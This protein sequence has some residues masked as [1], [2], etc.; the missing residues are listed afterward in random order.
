M[1]NTMYMNNY[2]YSFKREIINKIEDKKKS[3]EYSSKVYL[4]DLEDEDN[5]KNDHVLFHLLEEDI[6]VK[7]D[8]EE[9]KFP[10][11]LFF[12]IFSSLVLFLDT[13]RHYCKIL[14]LENIL[15]RANIAK[16]AFEKKRKL[17]KE[18]D[19]IKEIINDEEL[20]FF[21]INESRLI[22]CLFANPYLKNENFTIRKK[23]FY[24][25]GI[26]KE[27]KLPVC[28]IEKINN[29]NIEI[30]GSI[31]TLK[32]SRYVILKKLREIYNFEINNFDFKYKLLINKINNK[33][34][35]ICIE[36]LFNIDNKVEIRE[37]NKVIGG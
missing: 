30:I 10:E 12:E 4:T 33:L 32:M 16:K 20:L 8:N 27:L 2:D 11:N 34:N 9:M 19:T 1:K 35:D 7:I 13:K 25:H 22:K 5:E 6:N 28:I 3:F 17:Q 29:E 23:G 26:I 18:L 15:Y 36:I 21:S 24:L 31:E 14:N 37:I